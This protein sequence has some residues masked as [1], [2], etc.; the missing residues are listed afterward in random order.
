MFWSNRARSSL[1][2]VFVIVNKREKIGTAVSG[3]I[4]LILGRKND[5]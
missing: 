2:H 3:A 5:T 1:R 4:E